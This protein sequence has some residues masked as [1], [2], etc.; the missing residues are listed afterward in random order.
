MIYPVKYS[1]YATKNINNITKDTQGKKAAILFFGMAPRSIRYTWDSIKNN[2]ID[3][4]F[5]N[6]FSIDIFMHTWLANSDS[7]NNGKLQNNEDFSNINNEDHKIIPCK[8]FIAQ[9]QDIVPIP[10]STNNIRSYREGN[11]I[12]SNYL[13]RFMHVMRQY[14]TLEKVFDL[15]NDDQIKYDVYIVMRPDLFFPKKLDINEVNNVINKNNIFMNTVIDWV[16]RN[17]SNGSA[18]SIDKNSKYFGVGD[19]FILSSSLEIIRKYCKRFTSI[20][21][22]VMND[23]IVEAWWYG[24]NQS[25]DPFISI[26][27]YSEGHLGDLMKDYEWEDSK[28]TIY[29]KVRNDKSLSWHKDEVLFRL[30]D[31]ELI[32]YEN[33]KKKY[34][35][36]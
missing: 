8:K 28:S 29:I 27:N 4:L 21:E 22:L 15:M 19:S 5:D 24:F 26:W 32:Y 31:D 11:K 3:V 2:I 16:P 35:I 6:N 9:S 12:N 7:N 18:N 34:N 36:S 14:I 17:G 20:K 30:N 33:W 10:E 23:K 13:A 1:N 25:Y